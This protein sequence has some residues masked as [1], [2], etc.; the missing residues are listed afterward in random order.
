MLIGVSFLS[1]LLI[2]TAL[3]GA[4][5]RTLRVEHYLN[6]A[7]YKES[8]YEAGVKDGIEKEYSLNGVVRAIWSYSHG[9]KHG[10]QQGWFAEGP[11]R[12]EFHF[13]HGLLD[14]VQTEWHLNGT[15]FRRQVFV[16]GVEIQKKVLYSG[17]EIF[18]NYSKKD[19]R[20]YGLDGGALCMELKKEGA[21]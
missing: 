13:N 3:A 9:K 12:F 2:F 1:Q 14:G 18:T 6:G 5:Q 17:S 4:E 10:L 16:K 15:V 11:K 21:K 7:L 20:V 8:T 19:G